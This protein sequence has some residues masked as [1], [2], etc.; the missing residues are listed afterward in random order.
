MGIADAKPEQHP[1]VAPFIE[2]LGAGQQQLAD[3]VQGVGLAAAVAE[4]LVLHP[5]AHGIQAAVGDAHH[6][7]RIG[8]PFGMGQM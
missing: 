4:G 5:S 1:L 7:E 8:H 6:V 3:P 2:A